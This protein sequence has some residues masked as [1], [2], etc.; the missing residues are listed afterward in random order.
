MLGTRNE[1]LV[2]LYRLIE[3]K[4][5]LVQLHDFVKE[6]TEAQSGQWA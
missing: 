6:E 3:W 4:D 1:I 2:P 5:F